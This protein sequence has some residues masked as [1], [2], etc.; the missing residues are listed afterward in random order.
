VV[1]IL[2]NGAFEAHAFGGVYRKSRGLVLLDLL[3]ASNQNA[4]WTSADLSNIEPFHI[5][6][7]HQKG[8]TRWLWDGKRKYE[9]LC[10]PQQ[11][12]LF[13][14]VTLYSKDE[15]SR[16]KAAFQN[17]LLNGNIDADTLFAFHGQFYPEAPAESMI[18]ER[19]EVCTKSVTQIVLQSDAMRFRHTMRLTGE[20]SDV[21]FTIRPEA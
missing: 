8:L 21:S 19:D 5:L 2:L 15:I 11:P 10:D 13:A 18:L 9:E 17:T 16:R 4:H 20:S 1:G 12:H 14:S 3:S 7:W 6:C